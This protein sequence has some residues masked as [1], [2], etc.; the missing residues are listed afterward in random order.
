MGRL[1]D[2]D[3]NKGFY[4]YV[5]SALGPGGLAGRLRHH[6]RPAENPHWHM[7]YL[8]RTAKIKEIWTCPGPRRR[9]HEWA[10]VFTRPDRPAVPVKGFGS[11][12]CRCPSH[13]FYMGKRP[14]YRD[15]QAALA[16]EDDPNV[17]LTVIPVVPHRQGDDLISHSKKGGPHEP[18]IR[19][20]RKNPDG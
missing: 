17:H 20:R 7:D 10:G 5:G 3:F 6:L 14:V 15:W 13:L 18:H 11:S 19:I 12:D 8:G 9:E 16:G 1:G 4:V 2:I